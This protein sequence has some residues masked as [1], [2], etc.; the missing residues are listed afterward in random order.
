MVLKVNKQGAMNE[1]VYTRKHC[2]SSARKSFSPF[3]WEKAYAIALQPLQ[4]A[5]LLQAPHFPLYL[6][7]SRSASRTFEVAHTSRKESRLMFPMR[8]DNL[9]HGTIV[10]SGRIVRPDTPAAQPP[11]GTSPLSSPAY[12]VDCEATGSPVTISSGPVSRENIFS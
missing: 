5:H 10:P 9:L 1:T 11:T 12:A 4:S 7:L 2:G 6:F 3:A 8:T